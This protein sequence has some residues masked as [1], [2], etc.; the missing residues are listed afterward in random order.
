MENGP[1]IADLPL[2]SGDFPVCY[3]KLP[4]G[5]RVSHMKMTWT[6]EKQTDG[7]LSF[8]IWWEMLP[9]F[10]EDGAWSTSSNIF[11][12][13]RFRIFFVYGAKNE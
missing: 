3:V 9:C 8:T 2:K 7:A 1:F 4:E 13:N 5:Q 6:W 11:D 12:V 10:G